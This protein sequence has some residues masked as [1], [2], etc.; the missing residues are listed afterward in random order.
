[1]ELHRC[2]SEQ[3]A[4]LIMDQTHQAAALQMLRNYGLV[5]TRNSSRHGIISFN[6]EN[7]RR[8]HL[9]QQLGDFEEQA[10]EWHEASDATNL[11]QHPW[12][13]YS[14]RIFS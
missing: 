11:Q 7:A 5:K 1:M 3:G 4:Q 9:P 10:V 6:S 2:G 13:S 12:F 14:K 8:F